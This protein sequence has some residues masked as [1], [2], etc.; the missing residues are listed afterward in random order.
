M[1]TA[2]APMPL[3]TDAEVVASP[4][5]P[6]PVI[7]E[8]G[9][10]QAHVMV[11]CRSYPLGDRRAPALALLNNLLGG[12]GMN[13]RLNVALRERRGLVYDVESSLAAYTDAGVFS[14]YFGTSASDVERCIDLV[15]RELRRL[16]D[17]R[18]TTLQLA[19]AKKQM[20]GQIGVAGDNAENATLDMGKA[21]L[22][23]GRAEEPAEVSARIEALTADDLLEA[24]GEVFD[25]SRLSTLVYR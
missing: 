18:L 9:T 4:L 12:P 3:R 17:N 23:H 5:P 10:H 13:S 8:R 7:L 21:F 22:H 6:G 11:G 1:A 16:R 2:V 14:V 25:E 15:R 19:A 24:A 20:I